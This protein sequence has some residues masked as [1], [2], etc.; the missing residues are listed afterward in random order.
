MSPEPVYVGLDVAK[1]TLDVALRPTGG[2]W[3]VPN[4]EAVANA[5]NAVRR[6]QHRAVF[7]RGGRTRR[8]STAAIASSHTPAGK[9]RR[10]RSAPCLWLSTR[11]FL[12]D[13]GES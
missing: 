13:S 1:A 10:V 8:G 7:W 11:E 2:Q 4:E 12:D 5:H 6:E 3:S 9:Q